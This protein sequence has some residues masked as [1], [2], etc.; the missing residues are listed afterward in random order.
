MQLKLGSIRSVSLWLMVLLQ[1]GFATS[2]WLHSTLL[3]VQKDNP[4]FS[5]SSPQRLIHRSSSVCFALSVPFF[6][7]VIL[8][9]VLRLPRHNLPPETI[10]GL[11][12]K[13]STKHEFYMGCAPS[14][15]PL[16][17]AGALSP[18]SDTNTYTHSSTWS[19]HTTQHD[20]RS[21]WE[22]RR[23]LAHRKNTHNSPLRWILEYAACLEV[24]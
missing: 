1:T 3:T 4:Y 8:G 6:C 23:S 12:C 7:L 2:I 24:H 9:L 10:P 5:V 22:H 14:M 20:P 16:S 15:L 18:V 11:F 19:E 21:P 17:A 13:C